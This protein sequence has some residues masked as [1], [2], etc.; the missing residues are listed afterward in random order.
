M[1][2]SIFNLK[3]I[4]IDNLK[5]IIG[6]LI[7]CVCI[8][9]FILKRNRELFNNAVDYNYKK[10]ESRKYGNK[11]LKHRY[12]LSNPQLLENEDFFPKCKSCS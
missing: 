7:V 5:I 1:K 4:N 10:D 2:K 6:I 12:S 9:C 8:G 3:K 11:I